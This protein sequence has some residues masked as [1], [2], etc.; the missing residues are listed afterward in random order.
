MAEL[1]LEEFNRRGNLGL[2][3]V[4]RIDDTA[5][6]WKHHREVEGV[7]DVHVAVPNSRTAYGFSNVAALANWRVGE[8]LEESKRM[9]HGDRELTMLV[10]VREVPQ[11]LRPPDSV[12]WLQ[13]L[14]SANMG[15]VE[16][17][18]PSPVLLPELLFLAYDQKLR[19]VLVPP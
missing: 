16:P 15:T 2:E 9:G 14:D 4:K 17:S 3:H 8:E 10:P 5:P 19:V 6:I 18:E 13:P 1:R 7:L 11:G 12:V